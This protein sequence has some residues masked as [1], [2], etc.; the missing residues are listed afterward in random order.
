MLERKS[1]EK[2]TSETLGHIGQG[3][4]EAAARTQEISARAV[5]GL[6]EYQLKL[7]AAAQANTNAIFEC[8]QELMQAQ[9]ISEWVE[10]STTHSRRQLEMMAE[11]ARELTSS[12]QKVATDTARP[13]T[14]VFG[15]QG[16][17][18]S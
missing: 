15:S 5:E 13:L 1:A 14:G 16:A 10:I 4:R 18:M 17:H 11:Q 12:A 2:R 9:S 8:A 7:V 6:R 3:A